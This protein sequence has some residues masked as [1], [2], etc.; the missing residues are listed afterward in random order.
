MD[1]GIGLPAAVPGVR[2]AD[3]TEW[4]RRAEALG[5]SS[6]GVLDRLVYPN[7][8]PLTVLAA[9]AA[10]TSRIRLATSVLVA[11][12]RGSSALLAKQVAALTELSG[13]RVVL[14]LGAGGRRDDFDVAGA[15]YEQR[16]A[17]LTRVIDDLRRAWT[18]G[19]GHDAPAGPAA[20]CPILLGG[21]ADAAIERVARQADGWIAAGGDAAIFQQFA[22]KV[23][24]AWQRHGRDGDPRLVSIG[25]FALGAGARGAAQRYLTDYYS[26]LGPAAQ[27]IAA[28]ALTDEDSLRA[29]VAGF[30]K[31]G[32]AEL[33]LFPCTTDPQQVDLLAH[34]LR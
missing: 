18:D 28:G 13:G 25:H 27:F 22:E 8:E 3:V 16:G 30:A 11:P 2:G 15:R 14:G 6:L 9:A 32:C 24:Q 20:S 26:F 12:Y 1:I 10:V 19:S 4:A 23:R 33:I 29:A 7:L 31:A 17:R 5:F 34:A 21:R